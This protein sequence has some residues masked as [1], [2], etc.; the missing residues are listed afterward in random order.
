MGTV[1]FGSPHAGEVEPTA[2]ERVE[3]AKC[4][5]RKSCPHPLPAVPRPT[6]PREIVQLKRHDPTGRGDFSRSELFA[7]KTFN[8]SRRCREQFR[9]EG[10]ENRTSNLLSADFV[11]GCGPS[12]RAKVLCI[13]ANFALKNELIGVAVGLD[14]VLCVF[15]GVF[16]M[17]TG[18]IARSTRSET[19]SPTYVFT[20]PCPSA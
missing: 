19:H 1:R 4:P 18:Q 3:L 8:C 5:Q 7:P 12:G 17:L 13:S 20:K 15:T 16:V 14:L 9:G 2:R 6:S 11:F 10:A